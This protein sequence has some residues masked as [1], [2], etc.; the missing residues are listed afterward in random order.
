LLYLVERDSTRGRA[1]R[2]IGI[3]NVSSSKIRLN[4]WKKQGFEVRFQKTHQNGQIIFDLEQSLLR[5]LRH[6]QNLPQY[7]DKEE[8]PQGGATETFSPD[9]PP[10]LMLIEKIDSEFRRILKG[11]KNS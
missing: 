11:Q 3:T 6:D 2:K 5:W 10:E 4:H 7:L 9:E 1:A 8:M